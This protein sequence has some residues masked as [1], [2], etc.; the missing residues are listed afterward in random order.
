[1]QL[2]LISDI[3]TGLANNGRLHEHRSMVE[4]T[5]LAIV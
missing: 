5:K 2:G 4:S 1:L 3:V